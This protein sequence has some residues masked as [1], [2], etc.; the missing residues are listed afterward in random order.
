M[1]TRALSLDRREAKRLGSK[2]LYYPL[3]VPDLGEKAKEL[4]VGGDL[5]GLSVELERLSRLGAKPAQALLAYLC[6]K[7]APGVA[8]DIKR[9]EALCS[10]AAAAGDPYAQYVRAWV[11]RIT[12]RE[13]EAMDWLRRAS[14]ALFPPAV[15][16]VGRFM[17]GGIGVQAPDSKSAL[18]V[19]WDAHRVGH[20][21]ALVFIANILSAGHRGIVG[22]VLGMLLYPFAIAR[23][24]L[25]SRRYPTSE[26]IFINSEVTSK[27][28]F[29]TSGMDVDESRKEG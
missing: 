25:Y 14:K 20:R 23:A 22:R 12:G 19:L 1:T 5:F 17:V 9:A 28:L 24:A 21:M 7:G 6:L 10:D 27:G 3:F 8:R 26:C 16:D 11:C 13:V 15:V 2:V 4:L 29:R 18:L